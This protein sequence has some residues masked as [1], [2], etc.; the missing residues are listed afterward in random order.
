[1]ERPLI[2]PTLWS[3]AVR[4]TDATSRMRVDADEAARCLIARF[5]DVERVGRLTADLQLSPWFDG[6][7]VTGWLEARL[8]RICG[9]TLE[10]Y[11]EEIGE[12]IRLRFVPNGSPHAPVPS[13]HEVE[14]DLET[15]DPPDVVQGDAVDLGP[16]LIEQ[17]AL[18]MSPFP[19]RPDVE[20]VPPDEG[21]VTSPFAA[22][23]ALRTRSNSDG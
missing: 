14:L 3:H 22:L 17:L 4:W 23:A 10:P 2:S 20:F 19:R 11:D 21:D 18:S 16:F 8:T 15:D 7:E 13:E 9:V 6:L 5:L 1:M 12:S